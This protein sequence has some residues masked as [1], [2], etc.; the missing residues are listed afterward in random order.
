MNLFWL[1]FLLFLVTKPSAILFHQAME[2]KT[3]ESLQLWLVLDLHL[4]F[5]LTF[6]ANGDFLVGRAVLPAL[7]FSPLIEKDS[8]RLLCVC[9]LTLLVWLFWF[10]LNSAVSVRFSTNVALQYK[11]YMTQINQKKC[12]YTDNCFACISS[13][14]MRPAL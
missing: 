9:V 2:V 12:G 7:A 3:L 6:T 4:A 8:G 5:H 1:I 10:F 14:N 11:L 13:C